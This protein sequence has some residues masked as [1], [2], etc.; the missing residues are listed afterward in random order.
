MNRE[1]Y[2]TRSVL[3]GNQMCKDSAKALIDNCPMDPIKPLEFVLREAIKPRKMDQNALMWAG[4][5]KDIAEQCWVQ[6]RKFSVEVWHEHFKREYL[7]EQFQDGMTKESYQK[8]DMTPSGE[9]VLVGSSTDL[10]VRGFSEYLE[11]IHAY[12]GSMGVKFSSNREEW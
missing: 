2:D 8:W 9:R 6:G 12:G 7:P 10:T 3:L 4:P 1:K 5:L 11:Q